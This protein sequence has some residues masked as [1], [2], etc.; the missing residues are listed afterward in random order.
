[1]RQ[2]L[3]TCVLILAVAVIAT[4]TSAQSLKQRITDYRQKQNRKQRN[5][6]KQRTAQ[7]QS[8]QRKL[9]AIIGPVNFDDIGARSALEWWG[10]TTNIPMVINWQTLNN[11]G[12][13]DDTPVRL[14][15][16][17]VPA[18]VVLQIV[19]Q[20]IAPPE[21]KLIIEPTPWYLHIMTRTE[22]LKKQVTRVYYLGDLLVRVPNFRNAPKISVDSA[23]GSGGSSDSGGSSGGGSIFSGDD[24]D[25]DDDDSDDDDD[26]DSGNSGSLSKDAMAY[27]IAQL[28]RDTIEPDIW[29]EHGGQYGSI[30]YFQNRLIVHA[31]PFVQRQIGASMPGSGSYRPRI[32]PSAAGARAVPTST[33]RGGVSGV[34]TKRGNRTSGVQ[35]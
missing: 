11:E 17:Q 27:Q 33:K 16:K 3:F 8:I 6:A 12:I 31:A 22:A 29:F 9:H 25:D 14:Q 26:D 30:R 34:Q 18:D 2:R 24:D 19:L 23:S 1:M 35:D 7:L 5:D 28:I 4:E 21:M 13:H 32:N 20:Q 10:K 15:L